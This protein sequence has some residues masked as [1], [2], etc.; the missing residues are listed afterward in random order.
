MNLAKQWPFLLVAIVALPCGADTS[1]L[2]AQ[3]QKSISTAQG[4]EYEMKAV[5]AFWGDASFIRV[6]APPNTPIADP[7]TIY[8]EVTIDGEMGKLVINPKTKVANCIARFV[9]NR[10]FPKPPSEY[11]GRIDL[12]FTN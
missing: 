8:F 6:C 2:E 12:N 7:L 1:T 3:H 10:R 5:Q 4:Q 11:V 9:K